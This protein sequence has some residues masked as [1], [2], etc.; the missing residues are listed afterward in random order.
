MIAKGYSIRTIFATLKQTGKNLDDKQRP[1]SIQIIRRLV[2]KFKEDAAAT[3]LAN[4]RSGGG[5]NFAKFI[6]AKLRVGGP[7]SRVKRSKILA[8]YKS[9]CE[10]NGLRRV[11]RKLAY[12]QLAALTKK[13]NV[14]V[15]PCGE[16]SKDRL[17][18]GLNLFVARTRPV[19]A[20]KTP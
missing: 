6:K 20:G 10:E 4:P 12:E 5:G 7:G 14:A 3:S 15:T 9:H 17:F 18:T 2:R 19:P 11:S 13:L 8:A 1:F 16:G